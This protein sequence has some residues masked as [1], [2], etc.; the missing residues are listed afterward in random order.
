MMTEIY[1]LA[2]YIPVSSQLPLLI[3]FSDGN[4]STGQLPSV[5]TLDLDSLED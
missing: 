3:F 5:P 4:S 1:Q 2:L